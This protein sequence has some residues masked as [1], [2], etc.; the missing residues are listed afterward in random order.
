MFYL[1][2]MLNAIINFSIRNKLI[3]LL[4]TTAIIAFGLYSLTQLSVGAVPDVTNNQV[5]VITTSQNLS[6]VDM[7]QFITYPVELQMAN[8]PG[9]KE[10]RSVSKFGLSVVTVVFEDD[11][12]TYLPRQLLAEKIKSASEQIPSSFGTPQ[13]G[14]ITTGLGEIYQYILDVKPGYEDKYSATDLRT[15][16]DWIVKRQLSGIPGVVEINSW[17]GYLKQYEVALNTQKLNAMD[18]SASEIFTALEKNNSIAGGGYIEKENQSYF[19]RGEGLAT[20]LEDIENMVV[21][22]HEG[23][24]VYVKDV[25]TVGFG[26]ATRFGAITGN[27]QGEKV[28]GQ[29]MMLKDANSKEVIQAVKERVAEISSTLPE[30]VH[31]NAFLD[32][33]ELIAKTTFT[34]GENLVLG[35]L[36]VIFVV[37]LLLGNWR[38]GLVVASVIPLCLLFAISMMHIFGVDANLLSLGAIDF[39]IIIDGA[40]IIVE[41]V[42]H[43]MAQ[44]QQTIKE[45]TS[46]ETRELKDDITR[47]AAST[48]MN[49]AVFGQL[50]ILIVFIPIL[51][52]SGVEGKMFRP[53][54]LVFSFAVV[55]AM[56]LCFTY[57]PVAASLFLKAEA[58][59]DRNISVRL[60]NYLKSKYERV[61]HWALDSRKLVV[62]ISV[63]LMAAT[64]Y[65]F[66]TM[67][68][69]FVPQLD[70][71]DFVI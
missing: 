63:G 13:M 58:P 51:S 67:G 52:L 33:S 37:V 14:P 59:S 62:G 32:R 44:K 70:E 61:I 54:A 36:I 11:M 5:Q 42:A 10:I 48:M 49:S 1:V 35:F 29:V 27:G 31:I 17:G 60:V 43:K 7:E 28:L 38:S 3:V 8:L 22:N 9:V 23:I 45:L 56:L 26:H 18:I 39:G 12:G 69:E 16:Q 19:I 41:F 64:V 21:A 34:I 2:A 50:I 30:G 46:K 4:F 15:I 68:G 6:T 25:A 40:V 65:L 71:G 57:V 20:S 55:G 24:P 53:M 66:T 47:D